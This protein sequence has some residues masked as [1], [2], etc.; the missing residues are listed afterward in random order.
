M[1]TD[2]RLARLE[3]RQGVMVGVF[4]LVILVLTG[5]TV[6]QAYQLHEIATATS[7]RLRQLTIYDEN[8]VDRVIISGQLPQARFN[9]RT[10][11]PRTPRSMAGVLIYDASGTERGG[12]GTMNGYA[13]A[14]L[15]LDA[16][17]HQTFLL[18]AEPVG[19]SFLR[20]WDGNASVTMGVDNGTSGPFK[21]FITLKDG[22]TV[23]F[24]Q[25]QNNP[26]VSRDFR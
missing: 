23:V 9:G 12:Y 10:V 4:A 2:E 3:K 18:L 21:P 25:P 1:S 7:L 26:W 17:G 14:L 20:Q 24:A 22:K 15:T 16:P 8:G 6:R 13:N 5:V 19:G 11:H